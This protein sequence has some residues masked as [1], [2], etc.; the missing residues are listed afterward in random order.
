MSINP[1]S[2]AAFRSKTLALVDALHLAPA[3]VVKVTMRLAV[4]QAARGGTKPA[5]LHSTL[6]DLLAAH[7]VEGDNGGGHAD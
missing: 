3:D 2:I 7:A 5:A 6:G 4:E 1:A